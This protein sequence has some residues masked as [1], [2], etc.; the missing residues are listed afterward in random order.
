MDSKGKSIDTLTDVQRECMKYDNIF[1]SWYD[2]YYLNCGE[3]SALDSPKQEPNPWY[4]GLPDEEDYALFE[5]VES[6]SKRPRKTTI[7][8]MMIKIGLDPDFYE[9]NWIGRK[10]AKKKSDEKMK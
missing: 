9:F 10:I 2:H 6:K 1:G 5:K 4:Y 7:R 3:F 8:E